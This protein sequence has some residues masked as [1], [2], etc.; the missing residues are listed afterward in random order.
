MSLFLIWQATFTRRWHRNP[1]LAD[2][3]DPIGAHQG[4]VALLALTLFPGRH[5]LHRAAILHDM[6]EALTGDVPAEVKEAHPVLKAEMDRIE[7]LAIE[8]LGLPPVD[9]DD[10]EREMLRLCDRLDALLWAHHHRPELM[11]RYDWQQ[12]ISDIEKLMWRLGVE[13]SVWPI[14]KKLAGGTQKHD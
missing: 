1:H 8:H 11:S 10:R 2:T 14:L 13:S 12:A 5:A 6:G 4:R 3:A 7:A 9:L